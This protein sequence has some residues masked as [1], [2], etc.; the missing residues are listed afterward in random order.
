[1]CRTAAPRVNAKLSTRKLSSVASRCVDVARPRQSAHSHRRSRR[2]IGI[3]QLERHSTR[4]HD[5]RRKDGNPLCAGE[6][7]IAQARRIYLSRQLEYE[8]V[9]LTGTQECHRD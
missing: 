6:Q 4:D 8:K 1:M 2:F 9:G 5:N 7:A 3:A